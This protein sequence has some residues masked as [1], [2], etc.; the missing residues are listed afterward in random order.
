MTAREATETS[1]GLLAGA[2]VLVQ[3]MSMAMPDRVPSLRRSVVWAMRRRST[4]LALIVVWWW[5]GWHFV[6]GA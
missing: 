3:L 1:Y 6:T 5:L 4:Q 2:A